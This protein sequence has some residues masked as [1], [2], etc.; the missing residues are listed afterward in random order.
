MFCLLSR[1]PRR[2]CVPHTS[3]RP[4]A[5]GQPAVPSAGGRHPE[6]S[7]CVRTMPPEEDGFAGRRSLLG[8]HARV[9]VWPDAALGRRQA[10][11]MRTCPVGTQE[12]GLESEGYE[13]PALPRQPGQP[14]N[15]FTWQSGPSSSPHRQNPAA[16]SPSIVWLRTGPRATTLPIRA[17]MSQTTANA[18]PIAAGVSAQVGETREPTAPQMGQISAP[19]RHGSQHD[20]DKPAVRTAE[21]PQLASLTPVKRTPVLRTCGISDAR[22][23]R[24]SPA[25]E[26]GM[27]F[28]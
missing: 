14:S 4:R 8:R 16:D 1:F 2:T 15:A 10:T 19:E 13:R 20:Y 5:A 21:T 23:K 27:A 9:S 3:R 24:P 11:L 22:V 17:G 26:S 18:W 25:V 6:T 12:S 7:A 28:R